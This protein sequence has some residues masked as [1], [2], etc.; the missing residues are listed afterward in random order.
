VKQQGAFKSRLSIQIPQMVTPIVNNKE[1]WSEWTS[2][3][4]NENRTIWISGIV[5]VAVIATGCY[6]AYKKLWPKKKEEQQ[7]QT[8]NVGIFKLSR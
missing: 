8:I 6:V 7:P 1:S 4:W 2:R 5:S 3:Q